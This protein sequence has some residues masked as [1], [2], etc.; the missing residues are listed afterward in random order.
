MHIGAVEFTNTAQVKLQGY[1]DWI[2]ERPNAVTFL[3]GDVMN[4]STG[5]SP[6]RAF[7]E[8]MGGTD[9]FL[10]AKKLLKPLADAGRVLGAIIGNH[11]YQYMKATDSKINRTRELCDALNIPYCGASCYMTIDVR[12][13][14]TNANRTYDFFLTHGFGGGR[15]RG[16]K[17]NNL[18]SL[19]EITDA[20]IYVMG[21]T[22][23][24]TGFRGQRWVHQ[25]D[26]LIKRKLCFVNSGSFLEW[27]EA[28][29][30]PGE[31]YAERLCLAPTTIG[32]PRIRL[33]CDH[34][35]GKDIHFSV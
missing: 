8:K 12:E 17:I 11:E 7:E 18:A 34:H 26:K 2:L 6:G 22:H 29:D 1:I 9:Q 31:G 21:H 20:E 32:A 3:M 16:S 4:C 27:D 23:D 25:G 15:K 35:R 14:G 24:V 5:R 19:L 30:V 28:E 10:L 33:E 13:T